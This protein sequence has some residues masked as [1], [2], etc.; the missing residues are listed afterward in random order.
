MR[1]IAK[2]SFTDLELD[3]WLTEN[4]EY[5]TT[6]ERAD[7]LSALGLV[8]KCSISKEETNELSDDK[9]DD[10]TDD[11][12]DVQEETTKNKKNK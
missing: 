7:Y 9:I 10:L 2:T 5:E 6:D 8:E 4:D 11:K 12:T 1:V 3:K